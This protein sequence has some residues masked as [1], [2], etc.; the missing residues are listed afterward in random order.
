[1]NPMPK[2]RILVIDDE[3]EML[4]SCK[5]LFAAWGMEGVF[6]SDPSRAVESVVRD[7]PEVALVDL[8]MPGRDGITVLRDV[9]RADPELLAIVFTAYASLDTAVQAIQAGAH[10]Y[11]PKPF[12]A[13]HLKLSIERGLRLKRLQREN[14]DLNEKVSDLGKFKTLV[15]MSSPMRKL[16]ALL[17]KIARSEANILVL[18][19]SGTGK[20]LVARALHAASPRAPRSLV[21][22]DCASIPETLLES[23]LFGHEKGA[24]TDAVSA[25]PG[26]LETAQGGTI[27]LDEIADMPYLLQAK[28]LRVLQEK[29]FRRLGSNKEIHVDFRVISATN[30]DLPALIRGGRFRE[31]LYFRLNVI[32]AVIPPLRSR[33][34][35][36]APLVRH[37]LKKL[38]GEG[39][40]RPLSP[41]ALSLLD[42][43][44][45]PGN[46]RELE[47]VL[48]HAC[49]LAEGRVI[50]ADDLPEKLKAGIPAL[51]PS[52]SVGLAEA[53]A[54]FERRFF[55]E[56]LE[57]SGWDL[58]AAAGRC[59]VSVRTLQ[60]YVRRL[61]LLPGRQ[62]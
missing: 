30:R 18:G 46:V 56:A 29:S 17:K 11:I 44:H 61:R 49:V 37:F 36:I 53:R 43:Y 8:K 40:V 54:R 48:E 47:N 26:L 45:W 9:L 52:G 32:E 42:R 23:E 41:A 21:A 51:L 3:K 34:E 57:R 60:R 38:E 19:E 20:E 6:L 27:F 39:S 12:S 16:I 5:V 59:K 62:A 22:V 31:D 55:T 28:L 2:P 50:E 15:G 25:K 10:D 13:E 4:E 58:E 35:D 33:R 1:M 7:R 24:Y 14:R